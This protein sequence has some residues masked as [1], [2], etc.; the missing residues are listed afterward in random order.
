MEFLLNNQDLVLTFI[1]SLR[2]RGASQ[3]AFGS[4]DINFAY[5]A[6]E[7]ESKPLG[8]TPVYAELTPSELDARLYAET[9]KL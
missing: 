1:D 5:T 8:D 7:P 6:S 9:L 4:L 3:I 2:S